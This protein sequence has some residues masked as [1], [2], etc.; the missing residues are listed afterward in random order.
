MRF[1]NWRG[2]APHW[3]W[4]PACA[5]V[6]AGRGLHTI[7]RLVPAVDLNTGGPYYMPPVPYGHYAG[8]TSRGSFPSTWACLTCGGLFHK[9]C[10]LCG[11]KGCGHCGGTGCGLFGHKGCDACGGAG[12]GACGGHKHFLGH[13]CGGGLRRRAL[14]RR[15][16][17]G[18]G[19]GHRVK[20]G[21]CVGT[22][23]AYGPVVARLAPGDRARHRFVAVRRPRLRDRRPALARPGS[24]S[25]GATRATTPA[26]TPAAAAWA[27]AVATAAAG[28]AGCAAAI[29]GCG[30]CGGKGCA[31]CLG[32]VHGLLSKL[33]H[34]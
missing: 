29:D 32:A 18:L 14:R 3:P 2:V 9:C 21:G 1:G 7:P 22:A 33:L 6:G 15:A 13:G 30:L 31:A 28:G 4:R 17:R 24:G 16:R 12:C 27:T 11:G 26:A 25:T 19:H 23:V 5:A 10:G 20:D 34:H 8:K